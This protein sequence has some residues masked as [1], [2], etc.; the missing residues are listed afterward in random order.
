MLGI[1]IAILFGYSRF[2]HGLKGG[3][4]VFIIV[5]ALQ[6]SLFLVACYV[7]LRDGKA[8][9][10]EG[11]ALKL[12]GLLLVLI[13]AAIFRLQLVSQPPY[14]SSDVYRYIWD[15]R[16]QA[17][18]INPYR[19][20]P[21]DSALEDL[22]DEAIYPLINRREFAHTIYP[23][24][25]QAMFFGVHLVTGSSVIGFKAAMSLFDLAAAVAIMLAL[26]RSGSDSS[27]ALLFAWHPLIV[28]E[29]AHSGHVEAAAVAFLA[30]ALLAWTYRKP[31]LVGVALALATLV[32]FY[33]ALLIPAFMEAASSNNLSIGDQGSRRTFAATLRDTLLARSN[34]RMLAAFV[35]TVVIAYLPYLSV[36]S[37]VTGYLGGYLREEG[38]VDSG[39]RYFLL[40]LAREVLSVPQILY[41]ILA[42]LVL[43]G[44][45]LWALTRSKR[46]V[47][48]VAVLSA[49]LIGLFL[50][51]AS[52]RFSWYFIW[53]VPFLCFA[54]RLGWLYLSGA[55]LFLYLLWLTDHYPGI[56]IWLGAAI[57]A[58]ALVL[59]AVEWVKSGRRRTALLRESVENAR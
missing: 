48:H 50:L 4:S 57:Y 35:T 49:A 15:G 31:T 5:L 36:G 53:I 3:I 27:R 39:N 30:A 13:F 42:A 9:G 11:R 55:A 47:S 2:L 10:V 34:L 24:A 59:L 7:V 20:I 41:S 25:A 51:L 12:T 19:Y 43:A 1:G 46:S 32:K 17:T 45:A 38:F 16:V 54:P 56:P 29:S 28:W 18:G 22:R 14:L 6:F 8:R 58:P 44:F 21:A 26:A 37:Q 52:P 40:A 33:P 23:P